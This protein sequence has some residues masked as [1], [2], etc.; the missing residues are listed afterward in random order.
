MK[1]FPDSRSSIFHPRSTS[2][3][4][5][6]CH[7]VSRRTSGNG[8]DSS[9]AIV[10]ASFEPDFRTA[11]PVLP[12]VQPLFHRVGAEARSAARRLARREAA[13]QMP[14]LPPRRLRSALSRIDRPRVTPAGSGI[15]RRGR[16]RSARPAGPAWSAARGCA[17]RWSAP[18]RWRLHRGRCRAV[19][20][21]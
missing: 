1:V 12:D 16:C 14:S 18:G 17:R 21:G 10:P 11:V 8:A 3:P 6:A 15:P 20:G 13:L 4:A 19:R 2:P 5:H 9:G 7:E